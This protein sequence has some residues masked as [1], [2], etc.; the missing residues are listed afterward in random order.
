MKY[1]MIGIMAT[2]M[3]VRG[4][5]DKLSE[6]RLSA[7]PTDANVLNS[8]VSPR[9]NELSQSAR[10]SYRTKES[11]GEALMLKRLAAKSGPQEA[12][13]DARDDQHQLLTD[14][15]RNSSPSSCAKLSKFMKRILGRSSVS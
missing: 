15:H 11:E 4:M 2:S 14:A 12:D 3:M 9:V 13:N 8:P 5:D 6:L 7:S 10:K 1:C